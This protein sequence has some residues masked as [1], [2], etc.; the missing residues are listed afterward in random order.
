MSKRQPDKSLSRP[1]RVMLVGV[2]LAADFSGA[3]ETREREFQ[4]A[5][6]EAVELVAA[7][8]GELVQIE[9]AKRERAHS[10]LFVGTGKADE[11]AEVVREHEIELV[12]FNHE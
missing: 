2:M 6:Q 4:A 5:L 12:V 10:A 3:N 9:Q 8:G 7:T 11:L 1:E